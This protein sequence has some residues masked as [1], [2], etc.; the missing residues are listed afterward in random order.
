MVKWFLLVANFAWLG[1]N[2]LCMVFHVFE[3][4]QWAV[5]I[6]SITETAKLVRDGSYSL[7]DMEKDYGDSYSLVTPADQGQAFSSKKYADLKKTFSADISPH[8]SYEVENEFHEIENKL[9]VFPEI[10]IYEFFAGNG[11]TLRLNFYSRE[12]KILDF[13]CSL[14][15]NIKNE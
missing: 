5:S 14:V 7:D 9:L 6:A 8:L 13:S 12:H 11:K 15:E 10:Y 4:A 3:R 1:G 2:I